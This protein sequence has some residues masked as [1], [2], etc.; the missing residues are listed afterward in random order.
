L[1][2]FSSLLFP[3]DRLSFSEGAEA[4]FEKM[5]V[6]GEEAMTEALCVSIKHIPG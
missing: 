2:N 4:I 5:T 3:S 6:T 1:I